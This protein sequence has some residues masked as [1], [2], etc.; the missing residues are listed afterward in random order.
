M[1]E[2]P[3]L[4]VYFNAGDR[5]VW[6]TEIKSCP[7][8]I[9]TDEV[10][11]SM[12]HYCSLDTKLCEEIVL[13]QSEKFQKASS[14]SISPCVYPIF[15]YGAITH[16]RTYPYHAAMPGTVHGPESLRRSE[17]L[18]KSSLQTN[19]PFIEIGATKGRFVPSLELPLNHHKPLKYR[20]ENTSFSI[21]F[22]FKYNHLVLHNVKN[23][24][25]KFI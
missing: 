20:N 17:K 10:G 24:E 2:I 14:F 21:K 12:H 23:I 9:C 8:S 7:D 13:E 15:I 5:T 6:F 16:S 19:A 3:H 22:C 11:N 18:S 4:T 25:G 1:V